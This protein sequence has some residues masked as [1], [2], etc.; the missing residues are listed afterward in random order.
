MRGIRYVLTACGAL[1]L[2]VGLV[3][4]VRSAPVEERQGSVTV[5]HGGVGAEDR[6][7]MQGK[8]AQYNLQLT[9]A[10][11]GSG[12]YLSAVKV[13]IRDARGATV[14]DTTASGPWL[15]AR[16]PQGEFSVAAQA[17][18]Q[19]LTQKLSIP[20]SGRRDWVFRFDAPAEPR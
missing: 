1:G 19:T 20:A 9:F 7:A 6:A 17:G 15:F 10:G 13:T 18:G 14:L 12:E 16:L 4:P 3:A 11:R 2:V 5:L 8:A